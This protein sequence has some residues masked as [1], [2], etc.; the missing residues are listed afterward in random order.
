M[1]T[2]NFL[3]DLEI[4]NSLELTVRALNLLHN[5]GIIL[6]FN[7]KIINLIMIVIIKKISK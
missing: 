4:I 6:Y 1:K 2:K 5:N 3:N 7:Y